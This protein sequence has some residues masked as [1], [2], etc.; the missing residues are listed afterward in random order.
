MLDVEELEVGV[1]FGLWEEEIGHMFQKIGGIQANS[2]NFLQDVLPN[3][4][5][6]VL[7]RLFLRLMPILVHIVFN[8]L[9]WNLQNINNSKDDQP[10]ADDVDFDNIQQF[11]CKLQIVDSKWILNELDLVV[12]TRLL[13]KQ[14]Q[15]LL[16]HDGDSLAL[17]WQGGSVGGKPKVIGKQAQTLLVVLGKLH[18]AAKLP[19]EPDEITKCQHLRVVDQS[20]YLKQELVRRCNWWWILKE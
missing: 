11:D 9:P 12:D 15:V 20:A 13:L 10:F 2:E 7:I 19:D 17:L 14:I 18:I 5:G 1:E 8:L 16:V 6:S 3:S 4:V